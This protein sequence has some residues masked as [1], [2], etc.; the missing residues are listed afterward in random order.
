MNAPSPRNSAASSIRAPRRSS[1]PGGRCPAPLGGHVVLVAVRL[2][3][4]VHVGVGRRVDTGDEVAHAVRVDAE[5]EPPLRLELVALGDRD[6]AHVVAEAGDATASQ[7]SAL[8]ACPD[9]DPVLDG[10]IGPVPDHDRAFEPKPGREEP[11][12]AVAM[13]AW[14]RFMKS[15]S[16]AST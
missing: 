3:E 15:M 1:E 8:A 14:F 5:P 12:L 6:L 2:D 13:R 9:A 7:S 10:C 16:M 4:L 11:E